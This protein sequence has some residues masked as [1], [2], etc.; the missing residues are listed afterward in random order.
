MT[1]QELLRRKAP[2]Y[3][4]C[5]I[6][7]CPLHENCLHWLIGPEVDADN[8]NVVCVNPTNPK[9]NSSN[10]PLYR[11]ARKGVYARGMRHFFELMPRTVEV[12][13][14]KSLISL[15]TRKRFYEYRNGRRLIAP[16]M[17]DIIAT[18]CHNCGWTG[19]LRYD[20]WEEDFL[21]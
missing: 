20:G 9:V 11:E 6:D 5:Y 19:D 3:L 12:N 4:P 14:K 16:E 7:Q 2:H 13:I 18:F 21:W 8:L 1:D 10:C 17:Q 15:Y